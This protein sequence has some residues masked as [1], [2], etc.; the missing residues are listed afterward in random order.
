[1]LPECMALIK[2]YQES[3]EQYWAREVVWAVHQVQK[4]GNIL[5]WRRIRDLTN[6]RRKDFEACLLYIDTL[7]D[8]EFA[9]RIRGLL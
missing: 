5:V 4:D 8:A 6:L 1:M 2:S 9:E 3:Q 7:V